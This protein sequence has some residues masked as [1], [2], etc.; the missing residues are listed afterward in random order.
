MD[1]CVY[2]AD[3]NSKSWLKTSPA[4][5]RGGG[6]AFLAAIF[7]IMKNL[8]IQGWSLSREEICRS[9]TFQAKHKTERDSGFY[10]T[11]P[12]A[13]RQHKDSDRVEKVIEIRLW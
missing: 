12:Y 1:P 2:G 9:W 10:K 5:L 4:F 3:N 7:H 8:G 11:T 6:A 13:A